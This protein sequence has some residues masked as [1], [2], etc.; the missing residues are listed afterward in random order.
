MPG[1]CALC[2]KFRDTRRVSEPFEHPGGIRK[3]NPGHSGDLIDIRAEAAS[4]LG[5]EHRLLFFIQICYALLM[6]QRLAKILD[7][8]EYHLIP[9][10]RDPFLLEC[11]AP[12]ALEEFT[13]K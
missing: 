9:E 8:C 4:D 7:R 1:K 6:K 2:P 12:L 3:R 13:R 11:Q 5:N 10:G